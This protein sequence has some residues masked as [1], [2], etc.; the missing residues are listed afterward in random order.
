MTAKGVHKKKRAKSGTPTRRAAKRPTKKRASRP[1]S[2]R[3]SAPKPRRKA[4]GKTPL[5]SLFTTPTPVDSIEALTGPDPIVDDS[6][7]P[8]ARADSHDRSARAA[9]SAE[10]DE[11]ERRAEKRR[12]ERD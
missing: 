6:N 12:G 8:H 1:S 5:T 4:R 3:A 10:E 11:D 9:S 2:I 7:G